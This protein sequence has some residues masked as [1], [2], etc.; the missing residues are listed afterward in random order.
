[1][2][3][4]QNTPPVLLDD[5]EVERL[6][7]GSLGPVDFVESVYRIDGEPADWL[8]RVV[9]STTPFSPAAGVV[10]LLQHAH[11]DVVETVQLVATGDGT[12]LSYVRTLQERYFRPELESHF[13]SPLARAGSL[14]GQ[15]TV[16]GFPAEAARTAS[17][18]AGF[19][20]ALGLH[21]NLGDGWFVTLLVP[22]TRVI[23][24]PRSL[25]SRWSRLSHHLGAG[26]RL[27]RR[28]LASETHPDMVFT[29]QGAIVHV[30][31]AW[32]GSAAPRRVSDASQA[33]AVARGPMRYD[34]PDDALSIWRGLIDGR[35]SLADRVEPDG[36]RFIVAYPNEPDL[37]R[38]AL[39]TAR[40]AVVAR[41]AADGAALKEIAYALGVS[42]A[43]VQGA[44]GRAMR[45][46]RVTTRAEL[47]RVVH[48]TRLT[49]PG[50]DIVQV[51]LVGSEA[52]FAGLAP[53]LREVAELAAAGHSVAAIAQLRGTSESTVTHQLSTVYT[54]LG[55]SS[56]AELA[57]RVGGAPARDA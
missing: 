2:A 30:S 19:A 39:I 49:S 45:K 12:S 32:A 51:P 34:A 27:R 41:H 7:V 24:E 33:V 4:F 57:A 3:H 54:R 38:P 29:P 35:W 28:L 22:A 16:A 25:R 53:G 18:A 36:Q 6:R 13:R 31:A 56:K 50:D 9:A 42:I 15:F 21:A 52:A 10:G 20:D 46:L 14:V 55:V 23:A 26:L 37:V 47:A 44:L 43:T 1:M 48:A 8:S 40:E 5:V 11:G 17:K